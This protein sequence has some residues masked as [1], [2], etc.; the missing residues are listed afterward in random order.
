MLV[1]SHAHLSFPQFEQD[2]EEVIARAQDA[3]VTRIIDVGTNLE[4]S[5]K[6]IALSESADGI[7]ASAGFHPA[8]SEGANPEALAQLPELLNRDRVVA[9]GETG[10]DFYRD[11]A[12]RDVQEKS[13]RAHIR[14]AKE[15]K[16][17]LIIHSRS[18]E[19]S[20]LDV[21]EEEDAHLV[22]GV[23]HCFAGTADQAGR[24]VDLNFH[25]GFGGI[26]TFKNAAALA[27]ALSIPTNRLVFETDC[28]FLAPV[29]RR[30]KRNEPA[31][32]RHVAEYLAEMGPESFGQLCERTTANAVA[33]FGLS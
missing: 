10:L 8:D 26:V 24:A 18:A 31:Y 13:F 32:V 6:A 5:R 21:L 2:L 33:L 29:P 11:D 20:V 22:G 4:T 25:L 12:P 23:L 27:V 17:P 30:G 14:L 15:L 7:F 19:A 3:G 1:D 16:L 9:V 28:P